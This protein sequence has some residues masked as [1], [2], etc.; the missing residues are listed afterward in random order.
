MNVY[1]VRHGETT[2]N[3]ERVHQASDTTLSE[4]GIAQA[5]VVAKRFS[6]IPVDVI[7]SSTLKRARQTAEIIAGT[8]QKPVQYSTLF[9]ERKRPQ[10]LE[11]KHAEDP[12]AVRVKKLMQDHYHDRAWRY[13]AEENFSDIK[14]RALKAIHY[15]ENIDQE[16]VLVVSHGAFVRALVSAMAFGPE[17]KSAEEQTLQ[18][19]MRLNN[20]GISVCKYE[21]E[22]WELLSWN[23]RAHLG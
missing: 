9:A 10:E 2:L 13:A 16:N 3:A 19:F 14:R 6:H 22:K 17:L 18:H 12:Q 23:D 15:L 21:N 8:I 4:K 20:T 7:V 5:K 1:L 11:G